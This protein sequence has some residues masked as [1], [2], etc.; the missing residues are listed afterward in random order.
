MKQKFS[1]RLPDI[2]NIT[3]S[4]AL[5][6]LILV[7]LTTLV[8]SPTI[9]NKFRSWDDNYYITSNQLIKDF[10]VDGVKTLWTKR[11]GLGGTRLTLTSFMLD[12]KLWGLNPAYFHAENVLWHVSNTVLLFFLILRLFRKRDIAFI[13]AILFAIHP[14][15][16]ESVAWA[17]ERKDVLYTFFLLLCLHAYIYYVRTEKA[18]LKVIWW[19]AWMLTFYLSWHSKFSAVAIP[20]LLFLM[21]YGLKRRF[22]LWVILEKIPMLWF[23]GSEVYRLTIGTQS[24]MGFQ[25][26]KLVQDLH[27]SFSYSLLDKTLL[28]SYSLLFYLLRFILPVNLTAIVPYPLKLNGHF[29]QEYYIALLLCILLIAFVIFLFVRYRKTCG[30][31]LFGL[32]FFLLPVSIFLHFVSIKGVVVVADRYT[33]V[34]YIGLSLMLSFFITGIKKQQVRNYA[35]TAFGLIVIVFSVASHQRTKVWKDDLTLFTDVLK[36]DPTVIEALNNRGNAYNHLGRYDLAIKD[37]SR[38]IELNPS[39]KFLYNNR[40]Q[41][42]HR[43]DSNYLAIQDLNKAIELDPY[44]L[45]AYLNKGSLQLI[46]NQPEKAIETYST[47]I[48]IA[49]YRAK[50]YLTRGSIY[51]SLG[52]MD[53]AL[54]DFTKAIMVFPE[55]YD[56]YFG[57]GRLYTENGEYHNALRDF[58]EAARLMPERAVVYNEIGYIYNTQQEYTTALIELN[59]AI[60]LNPELAEAYNNRGITHFNLNEFLQALSDFNKAIELAPSFSQAYSNR[61]NLFSSQGNI[62]QALEDYRQAVDLDPGNCINLINLGNA[63]F[64]S[65]EIEQAC[66]SWKEA[67]LCDGV[68]TEH[69]LQTYCK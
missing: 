3:R 52:K 49:P 36:K 45:D 4:N 30:K 18:Y 42:Y 29:P 55:S 65:G 11:T 47:A 37:F 64:Q 2:A 28:A 68:P 44:F 14:M 33:Y 25:G 51:Q 32:L 56:A 39:Y 13:T 22:T 27:P 53:E 35:W 26:R 19:L 34:P 67:E 66:L 59:K 7:F 17:V 40:A 6:V 38:G 15:H 58:R 21:D 12:Y 41:T 16:V 50:L 48:L 43:I 8:F 20:F 1:G 10:S 31:Y 61:G 5:I 57:R 23:V 69:L 62:G 9:H 54:A 60:S 63:Y 46:I 24:N